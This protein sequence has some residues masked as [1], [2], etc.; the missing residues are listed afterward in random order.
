MDFKCDPYNK[1][2]G[3][4]KLDSYTHNNWKDFAGCWTCKCGDTICEHHES[5]CI[6]GVVTGGRSM[7]P[8]SVAIEIL[9]KYL[10]IY[11]K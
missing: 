9:E 1:T 4:S 2:N 8:R 10:H 6:F 5:D 7:L 11:Y 3:L